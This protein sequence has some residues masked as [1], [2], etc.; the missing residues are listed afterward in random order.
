MMTTSR[1]LG[2]QGEDAAC[3]WLE[4]KGYRIV[5]RN[6]LCL[7]GEIDIVAQ[8]G[9]LWVFIE[10][11]T[12]RGSLDEAMES[13][14]KSK[15]Q[16]MIR[17]AHVYAASLPESNPVWRVDVIAVAAQRDGSLRVEHVED[18]LDW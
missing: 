6:W 4:A 12:R 14:G 1:T 18:A 10:V 16:R 7:L 5:T 15:R 17:A 2:Q 11:R 13:I 8:L 3:R 9:A